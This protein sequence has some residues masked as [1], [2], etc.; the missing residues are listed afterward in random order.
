MTDWDRLYQ[1]NETVWGG[2]PDLL[3]EDMLPS[4][5]RGKALDLG[6]GEGRNALY[7]ARQGYEVN[8][9]DISPAAVQHAL[10][11]ARSLNLPFQAEAMNMLEVEIEPNSLALVVS[12]MALQFMKGS[13]SRQV[14]E[15]IQRWLQPGGMVYL[16]MFST[17]EPA[18]ERLVDTDAEIEP[19]TFYIERTQSYMH[20]FE[21]AELLG[22]F[23]D[24]KVHYLSRALEL[25]NGHP[26]APDPHYHGI[27][28]YVGEKMN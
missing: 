23:S 17:E 12:T 9:I 18:Y 8:G 27:I 19:N 25:D 11:R 2:K 5:P 13:E 3:L 16:T 21:R 10:E 22:L 14:L 26:G 15:N 7:L 1:Q 4:F 20:Y 24:F 6:M 28:T